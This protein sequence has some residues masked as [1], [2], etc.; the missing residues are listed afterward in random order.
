MNGNYYGERKK[1]KFPYIKFNKIQNTRA[2]SAQDRS[3]KILLGYSFSTIE[4][5]MTESLEEQ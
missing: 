3:H 5:Y 4:S 2:V 1:I